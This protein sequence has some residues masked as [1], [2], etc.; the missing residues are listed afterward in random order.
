MLVQRPHF[1]QCTVPARLREWWLRRSSRAARSW[2]A[3][4]QLHKQQTEEPIA[5]PAGCEPAK[6]SPAMTAKPPPIPPANRTPVPG[7]DRAV[8][9]DT[10]P[11]RMADRKRHLG[12]QG[13]QG[14]IKQNTT[15]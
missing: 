14:N 8:A 1:R 12:E 2:H 10:G 9:T 7:T 3:P 4:V 13:R 11:D 15:N 5:R 6:R